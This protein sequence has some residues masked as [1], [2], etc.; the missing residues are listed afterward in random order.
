MSTFPNEASFIKGHLNTISPV[1]IAFPDTYQPPLQDY[2]KKILVFPVDLPAPPE[3]KTE[4]SGSSSET[5]NVVFKAAKPPISF[6]LAVSTSDTVATIKQQ[7]ASQSRA[8]SADIQRLLLKGKVLADAKLLKEY[9]V[10]EGAVIN[11]MVKPGS[12]WDGTETAPAPALLTSAAP[13]PAI[14]SPHHRPSRSASPIPA[15]V[16]SGDENSQSP[17]PLDLDTTFPPT[18]ESGPE[19]SSYH[20][21]ISSPGFWDRLHLFLR[22]EFPHKDDA[23]S[24]FE[25]FLLA[26]KGSLTVGEIA[27]IR[28]QVGVVGM[29]GT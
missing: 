19:I 7:L 6:P 11:L 4:P 27:K 22:T 20:S 23:A 21:T 29:S 24:A 18:S 15:L 13:S 17:V 25:N 5:I 28:D 12:H 9:G 1:P 3:R 14:P 10:A 8:P 26:S 16:I 2:S